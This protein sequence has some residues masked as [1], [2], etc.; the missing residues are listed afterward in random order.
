MTP[1]DPVERYIAGCQLAHRSL[2]VTLGRLDDETARRPSLLPDWTVGHVLTHLARNADSHVRILEGALAG[3]HLEQY[4]GGVEQRAADIDKGAHR[5]AYE[6]VDDVVATFAR[7]EETWDRMTPEAWDGY[8]TARG[9]K[10]PCTDLPFYRWREVEIHHADLG[11]AYGVADWPEAYLAEELPIA[12]AGLPARIPD[13]AARARLLAWLLGRGDQPALD[14]LEP[15]QA[16][17]GNYLLRA[18]KP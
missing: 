8:G 18:P 12:L 2:R 15:W 7:L 11:M 14:G 10:W 4:P 5:P 17:A 6:L 16:R 1:P 13:P 9:E 3:E